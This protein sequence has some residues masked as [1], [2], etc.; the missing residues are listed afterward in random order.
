LLFAYM[1]TFDFP[2]LA[3]WMYTPQNGAQTSTRV[4]AM[5]V[6]HAF[7][8]YCPKPKDLVLSIIARAYLLWI[9]LRSGRLAA[10]SASRSGLG[11]CKGSTDG[12]CGVGND[13]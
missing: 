10:A 7:L 13:G 9:A 5:A 4:V 3:D 8:V 11:D 12:D 2:K 1:Y 6:V